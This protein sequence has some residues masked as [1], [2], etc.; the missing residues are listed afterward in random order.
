[1]AVAA[2]RVLTKLFTRN[3][4]KRIVRLNISSYTTIRRCLATAAN[5][6]SPSEAASAE[7]GGGLPLEKGDK[8]SEPSEEKAP[9]EKVQRLVE[10]ICGLTLLDVVDL[11]KALKKRLNLP[12]A[13][14]MAHGPAFAAAMQ[15][16]GT[17]GHMF[18]PLQIFRIR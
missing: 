12:D 17:I 6:P 3:S 1:M 15:A 5:A 18:F 2:T 10:E 9:S 4:V 14:M 16:S 7:A 13:P 11:N 8:L